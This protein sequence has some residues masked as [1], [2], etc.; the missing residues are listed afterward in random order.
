MATRTITQWLAYNNLGN[1]QVGDYFVGNRGAG[2][3]GGL[4]YAPKLNMDSSPSLAGNLN[5]NTYGLNDT[6]G[7]PMLRFTATAAAVNY[8]N[9]LNQ[10]AA[11]SPE[12]QVAGT[13]TNI[14]LA[15]RLKNT[16]TL[17]VLSTSN[18]PLRVSSG[19]TNQ[20]LTD[21]TFA[22]TANTRTVTFPDASGTLFFDNGAANQV[23]V[24][25]GTPNG[26]T[27]TATTGTGNVVRA[28]SPTITTPVINGITNASSPGAG[29]VGQ[30]LQSTYPSV[31]LSSSAVTNITSLAVTAGN[32][33]ISA[34]VNF[35]NSGAVS[36]SNATFAA[37]NTVNNT[38]PQAVSFATWAAV[39]LP[40]GTTTISQPLYVCTAP[41]YVSVSATTTYYLNVFQ[42]FTGTVNVIGGMQAVRVS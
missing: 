5:L 1:A 23:Y 11:S 35:Q 22:N 3:T 33:L 20:H 37:I 30:I 40:F 25:N 31:A 2:N 13:D 10:A 9:F 16:G 41:L 36:I 12:L 29:A 17:N 7:N 39:G 34:V 24:A 21:F 28:T 27:W 26:G 8:I 4:V 14:G 38:V 19:T 42:T 15:V 6:N 32:W 18:T